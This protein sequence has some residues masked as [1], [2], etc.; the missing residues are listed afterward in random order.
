[1]C[2]ILYKLYTLFCEIKSPWFHALNI[3]NFKIL[4]IQFAAKQFVWD[5][6]QI[7]HC[8]N[9]FTHCDKY[10]H[11]VI[12]NVMLLKIISSFTSISRI[13]CSFLKYRVPHN[14]GTPSNCSTSPLFWTSKY[15]MSPIY[16][17]KVFIL[18][19]LIIAPPQKLI[20][21]PG[22]TIRGNTVC[23]W[24]QRRLKLS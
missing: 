19:F 15:I 6:W 12:Q 9:T 3:L 2:L 5:G 1:M 7:H 20:Q 16:T 21:A 8:W 4:F 10:R 11:D 22:A 17:L 18:T 24:T 13:S 23:T 14:C